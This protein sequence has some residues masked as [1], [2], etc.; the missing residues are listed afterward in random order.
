[1]PRLP[2]VSSKK[3][4]KVLESLG[5]EKIR[6]TGSH[7]IMKKITS[8]GQIGCVV[9]MHRELKIGTLKGILKQAQLSPEE[10]IN[11]L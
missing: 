2:I 11:G 4:I 8:D 10:F 6:Q 7:V 1:M 9:P 3:A 5:F